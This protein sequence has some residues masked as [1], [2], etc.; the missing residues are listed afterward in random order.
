MK[1]VGGEVQASGTGLGWET[2]LLLCKF[3]TSHDW[4]Q[5]APTL[6]S[7]H[8]RQGFGLLYEQGLDPG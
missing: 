5:F 1:D 3:P 8:R 7:L 6:A 2:A 4:G